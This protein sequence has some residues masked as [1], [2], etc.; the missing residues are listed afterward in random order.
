MRPWRWPTF[1]EQ[2]YSLLAPLT[3]QTFTY[4]GNKTYT[5]ICDNITDSSTDSSVHV[6]LLSW[7]PLSPVILGTNER[8]SK[9]LSSCTFFYICS[10][11]VL[12]LFFLFLKTQNGRPSDKSRIYTGNH[13]GRKWNEI[14]NIVR[15]WVCVCVCVFVK[16]VKNKGMILSP[17]CSLYLIVMW[18]YLAHS[19]FLWIHAHTFSLPRSLSYYSCCHLFTSFLSSQLSLWKQCL[20][21]EQSGI[22]SCGEKRFMANTHTHTTVKHT[23]SDYYE[24]TLRWDAFKWSTLLLLK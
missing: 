5:G 8:I 23:L 12:H 2:S 13:A 6:Y 18:L 3:F 20:L 15:V 14:L 17:Q 1:L 10:L 19:L 7:G 24:H 22:P 21:K 16:C 9:F 11:C 4:S